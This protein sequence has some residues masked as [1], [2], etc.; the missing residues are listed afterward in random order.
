MTWFGT[1]EN[2]TDLR[3][4]CTRGICGAQPP[5][6][7]IDWTPHSGMKH[8]NM[9]YIILHY[10]LAF[11]RRNMKKKY[12]ERRIWWY[13]NECIKCI[14][15]CT[16]VNAESAYWVLMRPE[17]RTW[18]GNE[19]TYTNMKGGKRLRNIACEKT[20]EKSLQGIANNS[21]TDFQQY[22]VFTYIH[23]PLFEQLLETQT[24]LYKQCTSYYNCPLF[25][26]HKV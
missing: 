13:V 9:S 25:L 19:T 26:Q 14:M 18:N 23:K 20:R 17:L 8:I 2:P 11:S 15:R 5:M 21:V 24:L 6:Y 1:N 4:N 12:I 16:R 10:L 3:F 22:N 7:I